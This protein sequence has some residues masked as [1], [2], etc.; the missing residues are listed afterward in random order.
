MRNRSLQALA[1]RVSPFSKD[2]TLPNMELRWLP[3]QPPYSR[4]MTER[5]VLGPQDDRFTP[6][7]IET[8]L[9]QPFTVSVQADRMA[10]R[11]EGP[12]VEHVTDANMLSDGIPLGAVQVPGSGQPI[13]MMSEHQGSGGYTKIAT[14][15]SNDIARV[16]Q[17]PPGGKIRFEAVTVEQAQAL[18]LAR[19]KELQQLEKTL[20]REYDVYSVNVNGMDFT[21]GVAENGGE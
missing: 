1:N 5:V 7:G 3:P 21:V 17:C 14:V 16:A 20:N 4:E 12:R 8:F 6:A 9:T 19:R 18:Y 2:S 10:S 11:L 13:I 15:I